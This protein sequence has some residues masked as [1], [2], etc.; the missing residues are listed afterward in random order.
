MESLFVK[1]CAVDKNRRRLSFGAVKGVLR[2]HKMD[3]LEA[4]PDNK[5]Q[6]F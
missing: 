5:N 4:Y 2:W 6:I 3:V 1:C